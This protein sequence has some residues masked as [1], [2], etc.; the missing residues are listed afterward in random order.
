MV[1]FAGSSRGQSVG[2]TSINT[3][4]VERSKKTRLVATKVSL[5]K[6]YTYCKFATPNLYSEINNCATLRNLLNSLGLILLTV[7]AKG[8]VVD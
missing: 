4:R 8:Q 2:G 1:T 6:L 5:N 7:N 3:L